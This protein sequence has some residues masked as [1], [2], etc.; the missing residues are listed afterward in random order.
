MRIQV[1]SV[2]SRQPDWVQAGFEHYAKRVSNGYSLELRELPLARRSA[3]TPPGKA[4][5][6][7]GERLLA[8]CA[9]GAHIIALDE[10]GSSWSTNDL[11]ER[12]NH[13]AARGSPLA[14]LLGGPDGLSER[15]LEASQERWSLS[16]LT[17]PHGL[18]RI[19]VAEALYRALSVQRG[20]PYH[21]A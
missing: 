11:A 21:R 16:A 1:V 14:V 20:H 9:K 6:Q 17:L 12:L 10:R 18:V 19:V 13:W 4:V 15:C 5:E 7:E 3:S 8:A 2:S